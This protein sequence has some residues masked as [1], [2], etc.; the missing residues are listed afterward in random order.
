[1]SYKLHDEVEGTC[2]E[3]GS[4]IHGRRDKRF[5]S[6]SC[7]N[8]F[9]N[10]TQMAKRQMRAKVMAAL[11][12]NYAILEALLIEKKTGASLEDLSELGFDPAYVTSHRRGRFSH[13]E[14]ACFDIW[15]YRTDTRIFNVRRKGL[16]QKKAD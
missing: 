5:C 10:R 11:T 15:Y 1:M 14:Y 4:T 3:C 2:L 8:K 7:K 12:G 16:S 9:N 6:L 13:D